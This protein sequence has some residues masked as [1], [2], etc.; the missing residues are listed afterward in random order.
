MRVVGIQLVPLGLERGDLFCHAVVVIFAHYRSQLSSRVEKL[1][2]TWQWLVRAGAGRAA[3][4]RPSL[5]RGQVA[6]PRTS[7][8]HAVAV[9]R[10]VLHR[11]TVHLAFALVYDVY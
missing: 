1:H 4:G 8:P 6:H 5:E 9:D 2:P 11:G 3:C 7:S 10:I